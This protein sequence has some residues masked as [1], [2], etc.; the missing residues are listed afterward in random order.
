MIFNL[1]N[2]CKKK[3]KSQADNIY[4]LPHIKNDEKRKESHKP[5]LPFCVV[6][7]E[8][9]YYC[10]NDGL[11]HSLLIGT[12]GRG[13]SSFSNMQ[14]KTI[15]KKI[16][17]TE[18]YLPKHPKWNHLLNFFNSQGWIKSEIEKVAQYIKL[19]NSIFNQNKIYPDVY[20]KI[21]L[22]NLTIDIEKA[23]WNTSMDRFFKKHFSNKQKHLISSELKVIIGKIINIDKDMDIVSKLIKKNILHYKNGE[24][25]SRDIIDVVNKNNN[26][27]ID[28]F[29]NTIENSFDVLSHSKNSITF[30][31]NNFEDMQKFGSKNW[32]ITQDLD[33][34]EQHIGV[35]DFQIIEYNFNNLYSS[36][37]SIIGTTINMYINSAIYCFDNNNINHQIITEDVNI[38]IKQLTEKYDLKYNENNQDDT[39]IDEVL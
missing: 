1:I 23:I 39:N 21:G 22:N 33:A 9:G 2:F 13:K 4:Y 10:D 8:Y 27:N 19:N 12:T 11:T 28:Y 34:F 36:K 30:V 25:L 35:D 18:Q 7:D 15:N 20:Y 32:C 14:K 38:L 29:L 6:F 5:I 17:I 37:L 26:W 16:I 24:D 31:V 3:R